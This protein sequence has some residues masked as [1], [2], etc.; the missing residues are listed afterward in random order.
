MRSF[1]AALLAPAALLAA[2][3][4]AETVTTQLTVSATVGSS[5]VVNSVSAINFGMLD[6]AVASIVG[7]TAPGSVSVTCPNG[8]TYRIYIPLDS[9][10]GDTTRRMSLGNPQKFISYGLY[11]DTSA[12]GLWPTGPASAAGRQGTGN[13]TAFTVTGKITGFTVPANSSL[14]PGT[15][16]DTVTV[17]IDF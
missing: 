12:N 11:T 15:Y 2:P 4:W 13:A 1:V 6:P 10:E 7:R 17:T 5:C 16:S 3:A 8:L 9:G 14:D